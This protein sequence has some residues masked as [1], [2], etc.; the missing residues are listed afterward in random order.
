MRRI[1]GETD[2][3]GGAARLLASL[4][5]AATH[6][7]CP[8]DLDVVES[9]R[10]GAYHLVLL[11]SLAGNQHEIAGQSGLNGFIDRLLAI[12]DGKDPLSGAATRIWRDA[13]LDLFDDARG[14]LTSRI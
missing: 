3:A 5:A 10:F 12:N 6:Q 1:P 4:P 7:R 2:R 14:V 9:E 13:T 8:C 11:V